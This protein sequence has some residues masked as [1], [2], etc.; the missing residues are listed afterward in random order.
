[1]AFPLQPQSRATLGKPRTGLPPTVQYTGK[2]ITNWGGSSNNPEAENYQYILWELRMRYPNLVGFFDSKTSELWVWA[3][4]NRRWWTPNLSNYVAPSGGRGGFGLDREGQVIQYRNP[5]G[6]GS[7]TNAPLGGGERGGFGLDREGQVIQYRRS[8]SS[9][10]AIW[11]SWDAIRGTWITSRDFCA[12]GRNDS[13]DIDP[14][15]SDPY[16]PSQPLPTGKVYTKIDTADKLP[17]MTEVKTYGI[18]TDGIGNLTTF[19]TASLSGSVQPFHQTIHNKVYGTCGS[20][21]Q[22]DVA[23]GNDDGSGSV[24]LGGYDW[25]TPTNA[26]Y[27]QY[28]LLCL[29]RD[30]K[31]FKLGS[32]ELDHVY[33]VNVKHARMQDRIDEGNIE[34]N[35]AHLSGSE[36]VAGGGLANAHTGSN[37]T[38]AGNG[39]VLRL[40]DDSRLNFDLLSDDALT[41][42]Y[43]EHSDVKA[44]R[45]G[46]GGKVY[47]MVSGSI[48][49]GIHNVSQPNVYGLLYPQLG[50]VVLDAD[51]MDSTASFGT[52]TGTEI[53]GDNAMKLFTA[54]SGAAQYTDPSGDVLG[55]QA[56]RKETEFAEYYFI[57]VKNSD[58]NYTNNPT[59]QSGSDGQI[60]DNFIE[61]PRVYF[62][63]VGLYN[64]RKECIAVGKV[65]RPIQKT[66]TSEALFKLR[67]KY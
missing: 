26:T 23:Y 55:F 34:L 66:S 39:R 14:P 60:S 18:W 59:F 24:D 38:L 41:G 53:A 56:R 31:K 3:D 32:R 4:C 54:I 48:E 6:G 5:S 36:F 67:I 62:S 44:H 57:R 33:I 15:M 64:E 28:R 35:L 58:Y 45:T 20:E 21:P 65:T 43:S 22:F 16:I 2:N 50:I 25:L 10:G 8:S 40:I 52:V 63:T 13:G 30:Q 61:E 12:G 51:L 19:H 7:L 27:S 49:K 1:M 37:V 11:N 46:H 42:S 17:R 9:T 29:G 47:Y